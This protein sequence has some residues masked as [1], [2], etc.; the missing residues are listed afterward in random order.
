MAFISE[1]VWKYPCIHL[2]VTIWPGYLRTWFEVFT[3]FFG[4]CSNDVD[5]KI[6]RCFISTSTVWAGYNIFKTKESLRESQLSSLSC[7]IGLRRSSLMDSPRRHLRSILVFPK[8][9]YSVHSF[10]LFYINYLPSTFPRS[11]VNRHTDDTT[12]QFDDQC[13]ETDISPQLTLTAP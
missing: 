2:N 1:P 13:L 11:L 4:F 10:F 7:Q 5:L 12:V 3:L 6:N 8:A 9:V